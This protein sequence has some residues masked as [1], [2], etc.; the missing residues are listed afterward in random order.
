[1]KIKNIQTM[2]RAIGIIEGIS[3][4]IASKDGQTALATAVEMLDSVLNGE[5]E[6]TT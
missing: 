6:E 1:M 4:C 3:F 5:M 2:E